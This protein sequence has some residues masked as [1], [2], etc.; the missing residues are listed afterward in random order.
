MILLVVLIIVLFLWWNSRRNE[1]KED[2]TATVCPL[3]TSW[4]VELNACKTP[5]NKC[6]PGTYSGTGKPP[7]L[8]CKNGKCTNH[9]TF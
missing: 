6:P 2:Y 7:C 1:T 5:I 4:S 8:K 9:I 3:G